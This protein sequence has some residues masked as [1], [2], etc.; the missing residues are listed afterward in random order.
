MKKTIYIILFSI[1][2]SF[3]VTACTEEEITPTNATSISSGKES[4]PK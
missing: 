4:D 2:T 3:C 1:V